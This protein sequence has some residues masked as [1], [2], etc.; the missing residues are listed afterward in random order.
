MRITNCGCGFIKLANMRIFVVFEFLLYIKVVESD[1]FCVEKACF[2]ID[3]LLKILFSFALRIL[4][5][6][7]RYNFNLIK[8]KCEHLKRKFDK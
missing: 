4:L 1:L 7:D 6:G 8:I 3:V 5:P 2:K